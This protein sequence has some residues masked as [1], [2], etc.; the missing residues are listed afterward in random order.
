MPVDPREGM[1]V[2]LAALETAVAICASGAGGSS[3]WCQMV[4]ARQLLGGLLPPNLL[5]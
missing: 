3:D 4:T 1:R 5:T 2:R